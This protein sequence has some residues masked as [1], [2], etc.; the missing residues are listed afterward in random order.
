[1]KKQAFVRMLIVLSL[2][3]SLGA[4]IVVP[5]RGDDYHRGG[6]YHNDRGNY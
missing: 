6:D 2:I 3:A 4:C 5:G 1:M